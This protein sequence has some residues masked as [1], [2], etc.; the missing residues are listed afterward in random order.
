MYYEYGMR[1]WSAITQRIWL[2]EGGG[3]GIRR[4]FTFLMYYLFVIWD[5]IWL[6]KRNLSRGNINDLK[7]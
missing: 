3:D 2:G 5:A 6:M 7:R 4:K 1:L